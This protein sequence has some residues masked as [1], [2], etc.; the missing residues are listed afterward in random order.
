MTLETSESPGFAT[1]SLASGP[2]RRKLQALLFG[3]TGS[4]PEQYAR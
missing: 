2:V 3:A 1:V 4:L